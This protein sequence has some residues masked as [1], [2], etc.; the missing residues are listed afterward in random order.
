[1]KDDDAIAK[2]ALLVLDDDY[3][4]GLDAYDS[5]LKRAESDKLEKTLKVLDRTK[6][7]EGRIFLPEG[8][9]ACLKLELNLE[10]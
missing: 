3:G 8:E 5:L 4:I 6:F 2:F 10:S 1:M 9:A 7:S